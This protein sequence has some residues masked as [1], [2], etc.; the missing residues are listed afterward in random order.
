M[1]KKKNNGEVFTP[2]EIIEFMLDKTYNP[3]KNGLCA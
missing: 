1:N 2:N 3:K